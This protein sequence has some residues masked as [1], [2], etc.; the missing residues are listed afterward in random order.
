MLL[1]E[2]SIW[3]LAKILFLVGLFVYVIFAGVV[4]RQV[5]LMTETLE[6]GFEAPVKLLAWLHLIVAVGIFI[7]ALLVL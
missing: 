3:F 7:L 6:V 2:S 5:Y 1:D 4:V